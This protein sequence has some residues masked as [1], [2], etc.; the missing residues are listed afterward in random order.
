MSAK[1]ASDFIAF[2]GDIHLGSQSV[3]LDAGLANILAKCRHIVVNLESPICGD[4]PIASSKILLRTKPGLE[5][6]LSQWGVTAATIANNHI[7]DHGTNGFRETCRALKSRNILFSGAGENA[8]AASQP[9]ILTCKNTRV[10]LIACTESGTQAVMASGDSP[11]CNNLQ[12]P[13]IAAQIR[14]L[15]SKVDFVILVPHWGLCDYAYPPSAV[16][17]C[18]EQ[19]L[20]AGADLVIGHHSHVVQGLRK[21]KDGRTIA[22]SLGDC[23]FDPYLA[24]SLVI[25]PTDENCKG[26]VVIVEICNRNIITQKVFTRYSGATICHDTLAERENELEKR[27]APFNNIA[28]YPSYWRKVVRARLRRRVIFWLH[29]LQWRHIRLATIQAAFIMGQQILLKMVRGNQKT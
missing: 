4:S 3:K 26:L 5:L 9:L 23:F 7:F 16:V 27:S 10:G 22:Y 12:F 17:R 28:T 11:G 13:E 29:P 19:L 15:K 25:S 1:T 24:G 18:G 8:Q 2:L 20:D 21:R 6:N 14:N